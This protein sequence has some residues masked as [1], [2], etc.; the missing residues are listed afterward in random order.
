MS[1]LA[2]QDDE[3]VD[4]CNFTPSTQTIERKFVHRVGIHEVFIMDDYKLNENHF[5]FF[6]EL[7]K[8]HM[9]FNDYIRF[10]NQKNIM[11]QC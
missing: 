11:T 8:S 4:L 5:I 1:Y 3:T 10:A 9:Y 6:A 7:P 2:K